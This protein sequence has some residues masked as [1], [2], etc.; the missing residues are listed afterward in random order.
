[1]DKI[2]VLSDKKSWDLFFEARHSMP[3]LAFQETKKVDGISVITDTI[4]PPENFKES[5]SEIHH[6][7]QKAKIEYLLF[8]HLG[9]CHLHFHLIPAKGQ[10]EVAF[11]VYNEII[12]ISS[13]LGGVYSAEH[14]TGKRK[15]AD[16]LSCY[17]TSAAK[18]LKA[19]KLCLDPY[20]ILNRGNII[21]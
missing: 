19:A 15:K 16:F 6:V 20:M 5:L 12:K 17:G 9:D 21:D 10:Q 18:E 1:M 7:I 3:E 14:G 13:N 11:D 4:V 2:F 8:G